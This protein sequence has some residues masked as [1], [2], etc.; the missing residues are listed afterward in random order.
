MISTHNIRSG[1]QGLEFRQRRNSAHDCTALHCTEPF[2]IILSSSQYDLNNVERC[3]TP[4]RHTVIIIF[5]PH[6]KILARY[7]GIILVLRVS[8]YPSVQ[9]PSVFC[10]RIITWVNVSGFSVNLV[11]ALILWRCSLGLVMG[12]FSQFLT[13][14]YAR[15][16][17]IA[18]Y[19]RFTFLL[20]KTR[21]DISLWWVCP[22]DSSDEMS[23]LISHVK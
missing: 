18:G 20:K 22:A 9:C 23:I 8:V 13:E 15:D 11:Y 4:N 14:L 19:Y 17:I 21:L 7:Y 1:G 2:I 3:K 6:Y 12:K 10:I 5:I 16:M